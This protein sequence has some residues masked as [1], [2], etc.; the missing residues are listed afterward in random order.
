MPFKI[1]RSGPSVSTLRKPHCSKLMPTIPTIIK[2]NRQYQ[3]VTVPPASPPA[4]PRSGQPQY[5][6]CALTRFPVS[7]DKRYLP[8]NKACRLNSCSS[9]SIELNVV[10]DDNWLNASQAAQCILALGMLE[11]LARLLGLK[12][13]EYEKQA[14]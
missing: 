3:S 12:R 5:M 14:F 13:D 1:T 8:K 10:N 7:P 11:R 2:P 9:W 6:T 4:L